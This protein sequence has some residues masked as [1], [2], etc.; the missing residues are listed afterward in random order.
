MDDFDY[1]QLLNWIVP[2]GSVIAAII[3]ARASRVSAIAARR[4]TVA[5]FEGIEANRVIAENDWRIRMM[6]ERMKVW[7]AFDNLM[8]NYTRHGVSTYDEIANAKVEFQRVPF[9]FPVE[10]D[11]YLAKLE[12]RM[13]RQ[14]VL[15]DR[16]RQIREGIYWVEL[17]KEQQKEL[18]LCK[19]LGNQQQAGKKIFKKHMSLIS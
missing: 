1:T 16:R 2:L 19:W 12:K 11:K 5:A 8:I 9:L 7:R 3:S 6:D 14:I 13:I 17:F 10:V 15:D 4:S 18:N